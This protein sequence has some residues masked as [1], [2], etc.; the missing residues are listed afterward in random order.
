MAIETKHLSEALDD[1]IVRALLQL[2]PEMKTAIVQQQIVTILIYQGITL[3]I[4]PTFPISL[5]QRLI[6]DGL[7]IQFQVADAH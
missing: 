4:R 6:A 7:S 2:Y 1:P 3:Y 5:A